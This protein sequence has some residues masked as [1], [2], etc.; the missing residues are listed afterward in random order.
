[1]TA[2]VISSY[3]QG[4]FGISIHPLIAGKS[5]LKKLKSEG[6]VVVNKL[7]YRYM[8]DDLDGLGEIEVDLLWF[9][10]LWRKSKPAD[11]LR[12]IELES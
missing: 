7:V 6:T 12:L 2:G 4:P 10:W 3:T 1:M 11:C 9:W 8:F 5:D